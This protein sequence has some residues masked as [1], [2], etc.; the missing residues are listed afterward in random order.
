MPCFCDNGTTMAPFLSQE[1][2]KQVIILRY[3][4]H[5][6][7]QE[8]ADIVGCNERTVYNILRLYCYFGQVNNPF[9]SQMGR[10]R[11]LGQGDLTYITSV[12]DANPSLYLDE[13]QEKLLMSR[14]FL[15]R[16][17]GYR[18]YI[19]RSRERPTTRRSCGLNCSCSTASFF[20]LLMRNIETGQIHTTIL[21]MSQ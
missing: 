17:S 9:A 12:L 8:I 1:I 7:A 18:R 5:G 3:E 11:A 15:L 6:T 20:N 2:R 10:P 13:L 4:Q 14:G 19:H 21:E 16:G